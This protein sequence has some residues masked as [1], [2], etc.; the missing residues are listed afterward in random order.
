[1]CAELA[2]ALVVQVSLISALL[3]TDNMFWLFYQCSCCDTFAY[4]QLK[5]THC[6][7][8]KS[9]DVFSK[10]IQVYDEGHGRDDVATACLS[11][12]CTVVKSLMAIPS[13]LLDLACG[14]SSALSENCWQLMFP[15]I[16]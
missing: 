1:M 4:M 7:Y 3:N 13:P 5:S 16:S 6:N 11:V 9:T 14:I 8:G 10:V 15:C 2:S 12:H